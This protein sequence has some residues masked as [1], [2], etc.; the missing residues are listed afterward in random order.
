VAKAR[1][2]RSEG[3]KASIDFANIRQ[4]TK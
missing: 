3:K 2:L 1:R 4:G